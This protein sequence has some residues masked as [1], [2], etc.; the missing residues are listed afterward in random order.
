[1][2]KEIIAGEMDREEKKEKVRFSRK[3]NL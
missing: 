2:V 1:M 3:I